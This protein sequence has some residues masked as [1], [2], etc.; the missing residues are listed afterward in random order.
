MSEQNTKQKILSEALTLFSEH[1]YNAV[2][3]GQIAFAV[4]IKAPSLYKHYKSKQDIF[5]AILSEMKERYEKQVTLLNMDGSNPAADVSVFS[6]ISEEMLI[7]MG[8]QLFLYFL[9]DEF[10]CRF[11]KMLTLEQ[12]HSAELAALFSKQ[13][14]DDPLSYQGMLFGLLFSQGV[15]VE[16]PPD[17][18]AL[19]FYAP[20]YLLLSQCDRQPER[21]AESLKLL[22]RH[23]R[24]FNHLYCKTK[25]PSREE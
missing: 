16:A 13:Y 19:H 7:Q 5:L 17:I 22:E 21:E 15:F 10:V 2:S 9:H 1:G 6:D 8:T 18:M 25:E 14:V 11:R 20:L 12:Y 4:G 3:V 23:I 24:Q